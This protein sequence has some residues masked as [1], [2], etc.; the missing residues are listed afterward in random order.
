MFCP[1]FPLE[2]DPGQPRAHRKSF[3]GLVFNLT[4]ELHFQWSV[5]TSTGN[6]LHIQP[7]WNQG[8]PRPKARRTKT[9]ALAWLSQESIWRF[10]LRPAYSMLFITQS[11]LHLASTPPTR[12]LSNLAPTHIHF[13]LLWCE[14]QHWLPWHASS[15]HFVNFF[16]CCKGHNQKSFPDCSNPLYLCLFV[17]NAKHSLD[18]AMCSLLSVT[19]ASCWCSKSQQV[20]WTSFASKNDASYSLPPAGDQVKDTGYL[21]AKFLTLRY[22]ACTTLAGLGSALPIKPKSHPHPIGFPQLSLTRLSFSH[23]TQNPPRRPRWMLAPGLQ[24]IAL[25]LFRYK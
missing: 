17:S 7:K 24:L 4:E 23:R 15:H 12:K 2:I 20:D 10:W 1:W 16:S 21:P 6:C 11:S 5:V 3:Y 9:K 22:T 8:K 14:L 19:D 25:I 13:F 18:I